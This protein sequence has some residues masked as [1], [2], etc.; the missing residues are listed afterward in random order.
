MPTKPRILWISYRFPPQTYPLATRVKYFLN[1]LTPNWNIDAITAAE[2][3]DAGPEV[4]IHH[5]PERTPHRLFEGLRQVRLEKLIELFA[6]PDRFL[7]WIPSALRKAWALLQSGEYDAIAVFM[8]PY[9]QGLIGTLLKRWTDLPLI[10]NF[11]DSM[12]C[13]DMRAR[14]PSVI[15][16]HLARKLEDLYVRSSDAVIF[17]SKR[18]LERV[19][20]RQPEAHRHKFH[21]IRRGSSRIPDVHSDTKSERSFQILYTGGT[22]GWYRHWEDLHPPSFLK[23]TKRWFDRLGE[24]QIAELDD[25]T[26]GPVYLG[27]A[28]QRVLERHPEW[29]N[30]I[31]VDV[32]GARYPDGKDRQVI[33]ALG[34]D[35][36]VHL[37]EPVSHEEA[38]ALMPKSDLLFIPLPDRPDGSA[39]GRISAKTYEYLMT[40]R[41]ILGALPPGENADYLC[42]KPGVYCVAP[43]DVEGMASVV[44]ELVQQKTIDPDRLSVDRSDLVPSL[45]AEARAGQFEAILRDCIGLPEAR[46]TEDD[47]PLVHSS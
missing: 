4:S 11:N 38:L 5:V 31:H 30:R 6:W 18:N 46:R 44:E 13:S 26:H 7:F 37:H 28:L 15:H 34:L 40:D 14:F 17:V 23:R 9:S 21:L 1:H 27:F 10:M 36:V 22:N 47:V 35:D 45:T 41:P 2:E 8:M 39:G 19:R 32:Y 43:T 33:D 42:D 24:H 25:R 29:A 12:T 16:Y 20:D 3:A